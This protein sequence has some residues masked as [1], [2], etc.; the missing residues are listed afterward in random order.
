LTQTIAQTSAVLIV[1][2]RVDVAVA[3]GAA[4]VH[5]PARGL[6]IAAARRMIGPDRWIGRSTHHPDEARAAAEE[7]ADY[8]FL[9]PIWE[10]TS[11]RGRAALGLGAIAAAGRAR[12]I[13]IGGITTERVSKCRAAGAY[14][15]AVLSAVWEVTDPGSVVRRMMVSLAR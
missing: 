8:V 5:L 10:T 15:V 1:N 11:H 7:G 4:G 13:A 3:A 9:G 14:G 2:D 12:V 6:P